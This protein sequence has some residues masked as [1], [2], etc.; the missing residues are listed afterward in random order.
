MYFAYFVSVIL[1]FPKHPQILNFE[2]TCG[3]FKEGHLFFLDTLFNIHFT[4]GT[5]SNITS[6]SDLSG[7]PYH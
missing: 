5:P 2:G 3:H 4:F 6:M 7:L 1:K